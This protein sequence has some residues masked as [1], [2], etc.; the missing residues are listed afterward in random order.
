M[1]I[2]QWPFHLKI[3]EEKKQLIRGRRAGKPAHLSITH[4]LHQKVKNK[5]KT[6]S[7]HM[8]QRKR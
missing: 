4:Y 1:D 6:K 5:T 8:Q 3:L 7:E 2:E